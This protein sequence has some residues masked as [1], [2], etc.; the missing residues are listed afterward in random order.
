VR[1]HGRTRLLRARQGA[2][3]AGYRV[4]GVLCSG[5]GVTRWAGLAA[6]ASYEGGSRSV[7]V[8]VGEAVN[9][10]LAERRAA[11]RAACLVDHGSELGNRRTL[12]LVQ[13]DDVPPCADVAA[14]ALG[15]GVRHRGLHRAL[16]DRLVEGVEALE[17]ILARE[18]ATP[19][20][21]EQGLR[22]L[23][24]AEWGLGSGEVVLE[25]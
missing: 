1:P 13:R 18:K 10:C 22:M 19:L 8:G 14:V 24:V 12:R 9:D 3:G 6:A 20:S 11:A 5:G 7:G 15:L 16:G 17:P 2:L 23:G 25:R 21:D 4:C